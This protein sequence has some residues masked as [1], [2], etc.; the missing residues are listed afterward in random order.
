MKLFFYHSSQ[1]NDNLSRTAAYMHYLCWQ[2]SLF[3]LVVFVCL[4]GF[5]FVCVLLRQIALRLETK[6]LVVKV[7]NQ[8]N[9]L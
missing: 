3:F 9:H 4:F 8:E 6:I 7:V 1:L 2:Q 5:L